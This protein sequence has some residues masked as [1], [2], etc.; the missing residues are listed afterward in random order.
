MDGLPD[1]NE[2]NEEIQYLLQ[3]EDEVFQLNPPEAQEQDQEQI[4]EEFQIQVQNNVVVPE[5]QNSPINYLDEEIP[6][7]HLMGSDEAQE[8][9]KDAVPDNSDVNMNDLLPKYLA[10]CN[11]QPYQMI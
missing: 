9:D 10:P 5:Q 1:L 8:Q 4:N 6:Y 7:E 2:L 3:H 11:P